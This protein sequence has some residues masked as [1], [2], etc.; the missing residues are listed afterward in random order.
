MNIAIIPGLLYDDDF[1]YFTEETYAALDGVLNDVVAGMLRKYLLN[2]EADPEV[3][4]AMNKT[5]TPTVKSYTLH[6]ELEER[7]IF[8][9]LRTLQPET[10]LQTDKAYRDMVLESLLYLNDN[11][12]NVIATIPARTKVK[13]MAWK[14]AL[15]NVNTDMQAQ[16]VTWKVP[17]M[18]QILEA[19]KSLFFE[20]REK[21]RYLPSNSVLNKR[22][23]WLMALRAIQWDNYCN[24]HGVGLDAR[25][26]F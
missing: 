3:I 25:L 22:D 23:K 20:P 24:E 1:K 5:I 7:N 18:L 16:H 15:M 26:N 19:N 10:I 8:E 2:P 12:K 6:L 13:Y 4:E 11:V 14:K 21:D 9:L 17:N